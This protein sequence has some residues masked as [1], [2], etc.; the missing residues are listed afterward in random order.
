MRS[1][2]VALRLELLRSGGAA[3]TVL[4]D[5]VSNM[6]GFAALDVLL[7][8]KALDIIF[9]VVR[10]NFV[11]VDLCFHRSAIISRASVL[12]ETI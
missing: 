10:L 12:L 7:R 9:R 4:G 11:N 3:R 1:Q 6:E 8:M 2:E 5:P